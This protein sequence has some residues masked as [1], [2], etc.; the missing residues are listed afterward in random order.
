MSIIDV[1]C[2]YTVKTIAIITGVGLMWISFEEI[3][4][5]RVDI[6]TMVRLISGASCLVGLNVF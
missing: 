3:K 1:L 4:S 2:E 6:L 5:G